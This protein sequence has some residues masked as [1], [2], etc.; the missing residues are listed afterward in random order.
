[1][2]AIHIQRSQ[3]IKQCFA[4][5]AKLV[6]SPLAV[7]G[8]SIKQRSD[9]AVHQALASRGNVCALFKHSLAS[10]WDMNRQDAL[11]RFTVDWSKAIWNQPI[12]L[13]SLWRRALKRSTHLPEQSGV[14]HE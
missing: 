1:M 4:S 2:Y 3:R 12:Q 6:G 8:K 14:R 10:L 5:R 9:C 11:T 7:V 13:R